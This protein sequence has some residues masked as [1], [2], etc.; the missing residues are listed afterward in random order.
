MAKIH[1]QGIGEREAIP[2]R[3]IEVGDEI[4]YNYG[5]KGI[6]RGKRFSGTRR[7]VCLDIEEAGY[8]YYDRRYGADRLVAVVRVNGGVA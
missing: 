2:A 3:D 5:Y 8:L 4:I 7:T 6:V 1:L